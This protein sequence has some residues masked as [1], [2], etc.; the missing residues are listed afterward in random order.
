MCGLMQG[1][2]LYNRGETN[3]NLAIFAGHDG[4]DKEKEFF[5]FHLSGEFRSQSIAVENLATISTW[6]GDSTYLPLLNVLH[7]KYAN[8]IGLCV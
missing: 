5:F 2:K 3:E 1:R 6:L 8:Y 4:W 7:W